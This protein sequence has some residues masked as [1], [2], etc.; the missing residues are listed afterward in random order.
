MADN[1]Q[2]ALDE[3]F[4]TLRSIGARNVADEI[5]RVI[6]RGTTEE[7][8][9]EGRAKELSQRPL[10]PDE[11][12]KVAVEMLVAFAEPI[13]M[14]NHTLQEIEKNIGYIASIVWRNDFVEESPIVP[15]LYEERRISDLEGVDRP[16]VD[17]LEKDLKILV[18][19]MGEI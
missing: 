8:E 12:Y 7:I 9:N 15:D 14:K 19:L 2:Q 4:Q 1:S 3:L 11:A 6:T 5:M 10:N 13:I 17:R 16:E 18:R